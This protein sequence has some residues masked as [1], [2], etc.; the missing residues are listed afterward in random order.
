MGQVSGSGTTPRA[1]PTNPLRHE[2][3]SETAGGS[4][5]RERVEG[6][7]SHGTL[8]I[9]RAGRS[10]YFGA[11]AG[12]EWLKNVSTLSHRPVILRPC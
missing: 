6:E 7:H 5:T 8:V 3:Y 1:A 10:R 9:D 4:G 12:T 2:T 11:T